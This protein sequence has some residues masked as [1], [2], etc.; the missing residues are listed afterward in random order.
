VI[1][2]ALV[3]VGAAKVAVW[4]GVAAA[5]AAIAGIAWYLRH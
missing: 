5:A 1:V 4:A 3:I 2:G